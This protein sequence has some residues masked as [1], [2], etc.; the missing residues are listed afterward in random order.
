M[1]G[2]SCALGIALR[3]THGL[4]GKSLKPK[5]AS[6]NAARQHPLVILKADCVRPVNGGDVACK[7]TLGMTPRL[8]VISHVMQE[9]RVARVRVKRS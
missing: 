4:I 5:N 2:C 6:E 8:G 7:H 1:P 3:Q 9:R